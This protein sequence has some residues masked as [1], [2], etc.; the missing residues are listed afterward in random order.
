MKADTPKRH[1]YVPQFYLRRFACQ[2]D[3]NKVRTLERHGDILVI[4]R[5][6]IDGIGYEEGMHDFVAEGVSGSIEGP[7]NR[8]IETPFSN[9]PTWK[10]IVGRDGAK[11]N[12]HDKV[13]IHGFARHLQRR[14][15]ETLRFIEAQTTRFNDGALDGD[16]SEEEREMH[17]WIA[18][19][20]DH[21]HAIFRAGAMDTAIPEDADAINVMVCRS[22]ISL[23]TSTNPTLLISEPGRQSVFGSF[24][25][26]LRTWWLTL[27]RHCG[28][29]IVTG[30]PANFTNDTIPLE[31]ARV[32]NRQ[33]LV[34]HGNSMTVRYLI[35]EDSYVEEDL[36]WAGYNL[37]QRTIR[38][39]R[40]RKRP[41]VEQ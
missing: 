12:E 35:A 30:G 22:P 5:K 38:G 33:Y 6:S 18:A 4:D 9:S 27:D 11:L 23:R 36:Q 28:V 16:L 39:A 32:I 31:V 41:S 14:N 3:P 34:Q 26:G 2:D 10:K 37:E 1:H 15:L 8:V 13:P 25:N 29:F 40:W 17:E 24:F 21:A 19:S 20:T 7:I